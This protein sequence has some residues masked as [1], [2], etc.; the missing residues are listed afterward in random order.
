MTRRPPRS[1]P[2]FSSAASVV[3]KRAGVW[4]EEWGPGMEK[5]GGVEGEKGG[6]R[7]R[8]DMM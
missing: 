4:R 1:T 2:L 3:Y 8:V 7:R 6:S 5:E